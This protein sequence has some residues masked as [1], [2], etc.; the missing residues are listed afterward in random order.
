ML[1]GH[2][3]S[4]VIIEW[5]NSPFNWWKVK[6]TK[7][8]ASD[9]VMENRKGKVTNFIFLGSK[10]T[11]NSARS[12]KIKRCLLCG[13]NY[14]KP[15][16]CIKKQ[17]H[18]FADKGPYRQSYGFSS[19]HAWMWE[20]DH[21]EGWEPKNC[22]GPVVLEKI[23][24]SPSD[25][26]EIKPINP[27]ENQPWI[28]IGRITAEAELQYFGHLMWRADSLE[29][30]L[31]PGK[32]EGKRRMGWQKMRWLDSIPDSM[33]MNLS[34]LEEMVKDREAWCAAVHGVEKSWTRFSDWTATMLALAALPTHAVETWCNQ[35]IYPLITV[36]I[37][38]EQ[39]PVP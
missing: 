13:R 10:I 32:I 20:L 38:L 19:S 18:H 22:F 6:K 26:K 11:T 2:Y 30:T 34:K 1:C 12:H 9:S 4:L 8:K 15:R 36:F 33:D 3:F 39:K 27:K 24:E 37:R 28:F 31:I 29:R 35:I 21:K 7:M 17:R 14:G 25:C 5:D 23:L 16:Q